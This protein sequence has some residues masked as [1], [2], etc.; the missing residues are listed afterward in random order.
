MDNDINRRSGRRTFGR[1]A[2][3][4]G[5]ALALIVGPVVTAGTAQAQPVAS[6]T[7]SLAGEEGEYIT[8]G[9]S[10]AYSTGGKDDF[11]VSSDEGRRSVNLWV[12]LAD[13]SDWSVLLEGAEEL[14]AGKYVAGLEGK[15]HLDL[16]GTGRACDT[17]GSFEI[18]EI[19]FGPH[20]YVEKLDATFEQRCN[21]NGPAARGEI[22]LTNPPPPAE[23][24]VGLAVSRQGTASPLS[25]RATV[26]G[27]VTCNAPVEVGVGGDLTQVKDK[28]IIRGS[29]AATV[30]C[31][32]GSPVPW[33]ATAT[34]TGTTPFQRGRVE[35]VT[36]AWADDPVYG[37]TVSVEGTD[38]VRLVKG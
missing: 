5:A 30:R 12:R 26:H 27:E 6:G 7:F 35:A 38:V 29:Y 13:G 14:K 11:R 32:P 15:P 28:I 33:T 17:A 10:Y 22:H 24:A 9:K 1:V 8:Q 25:G 4:L 36:R 34:P 37:V 20:G 3:A 31:V 23:L 19:S 21:G 18:A 2:A 16:Y